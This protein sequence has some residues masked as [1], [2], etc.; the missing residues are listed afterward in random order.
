MIRLEATLDSKGLLVEYRALGHAGA[1]PMGSDIV[2][3]AVS[4]FSRSLIRAL[5]G[6]EG[7]IVHADAPERGIFQAE[8]SYSGENELFLEG[9][10]AFFLEG[11]GSVAEENPKYC[12]LTIVRR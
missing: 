5:H 7:I 4:A 3:A 12:N 11:L 2:C 9:V 6:K 1:G 10:G 8:I